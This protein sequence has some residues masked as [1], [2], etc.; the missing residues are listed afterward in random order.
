MNAFKFLCLPLLVIALC[1]SGCATSLQV[2]TDYDE[3]YTF[4]GKQHFA[5]TEPQNLKTARDDI[6]KDRI[7][8]ALREQLKA[9]GFVET[10]KE[11]ADIW[12]SFF[13]TNEKQTDYRSYTS[14]NAFYGYGG[15]YRCFYAPVGVSNT[16][17]VEYTKGSLLV[18]V[19]DPATNKLKWRG[20]TSSKITTSEADNMSVEERTAMVNAAVAA[21]LAKYPPIVDTAGSSKK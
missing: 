6:T 19:I 7:T 5:L 11:N 14:Y 1:C 4:A 8:K 16:Y 17:S 9:R 20:S 10:E 3:Q 18:D 13:A 2:S 15:C 12:I 21:I